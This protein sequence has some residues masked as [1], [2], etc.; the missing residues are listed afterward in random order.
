MF[1]SWT[2]GAGFKLIFEETQ[3]KMKWK[4]KEAQNWKVVTLVN[5]GELMMYISNS[6]WQGW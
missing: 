5:G 1:H 6:D 2:F 4:I 3:K